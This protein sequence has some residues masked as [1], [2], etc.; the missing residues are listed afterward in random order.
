MC[1]SKMYHTLLTAQQKKKEI[2]ESE[3]H[4]PVC[5]FK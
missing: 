3:N 2:T 5:M 4:I 1:E